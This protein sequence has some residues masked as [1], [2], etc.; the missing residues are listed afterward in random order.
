MIPYKE[1]KMVK[2]TSYKFRVEWSQEDREYVGTCDQFPSLSHL[3]SDK[4]AALR[5]IQDLVKSVEE[6]TD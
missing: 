6:H 5:G 4:F 3:D 1:M 2:L